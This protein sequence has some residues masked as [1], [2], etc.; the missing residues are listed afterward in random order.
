MRRITRFRSASSSWSKRSR[1]A[2]NQEA[3]CVQQVL[4]CGGEPASVLL[5]RAVRHDSSAL[6]LGWHGALGTGRALVLKRLVEE[7]EC[8]LRLVRGTEHARA[9]LKVGQEID[10]D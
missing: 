6:A 2:W 4:L 7:A 1:G 9:W 8:A 10:G 5:E 3:R